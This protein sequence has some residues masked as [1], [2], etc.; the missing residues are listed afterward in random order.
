LPVFAVQDG[1]IVRMGQIRGLGA[2]YVMLRDAYGITTRTRAWGPSPT[3]HPVAKPGPHVEGPRPPR[4]RPHGARPSRRRPDRGTQRKAA[5]PP[6]R[7]R[8]A[9]P[10]TH[11]AARVRAF[12]KERLFAA[13]RRPAAFA[14]GGE[15]QLAGTPAAPASRS[16]RVTTFE[17]YFVGNFGLKPEEA[18]LK[19]LKVGSKVI[20]GTILGKIGERTPEKASH[21]LFEIRPAGAGAPRID[22][23]PI[24][25]GWKLLESTAVYRA[26]GRNPFFG[27]DADAPSIGQIL[28][29]SKDQL[30][31]RVL[32]NPRIDVY[33]C[34]RRDIRAGKIDRRVL[35]TLEFLAASGLKPTVTSL[36]CGHGFLTASGN[37]SHHSSGNA[38]D[39]AKVNGI[40]I[41]GHQGEGSI[42]DI[43]NRRLLTLQGTMKPAQVISLM[44]Y[45]GA[46]NTLAMSDHHD[47][48]HIGFQPL[49]GTNSK[50]GRQL[51][52]V[53]K[54]GQWIKLIDRLGKIDN[55]AV[56]VKPSKYA[57]TVKPERASEAHRG[58]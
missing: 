13:P 26:E 5:P 17:P 51:N 46:S 54:P 44:K 53:L 57:I 3:R 24:L 29:M 43:T 11:P 35:A 42:T 6:G 20:A 30:E 47:H 34:G 48:I 36:Q 19:P 45:E 21:T 55:P 40:P 27:A 16:R 22:P 4:A 32:Q 38:V 49:Y 41:L 10:R 31:R 8:R 33:A 56:R 14:A 18:R 39:I 1:R 9:T 28:L 50:L 25:D 7:G 2:V 15:R 12:R 37:V 23:K 58:E 52:A